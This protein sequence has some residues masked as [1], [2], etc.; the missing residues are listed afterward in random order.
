MIAQKIRIADL[1]LLVRTLYGALQGAKAE[2]KR[3]RATIAR[4]R[5][6]ARLTE[7]GET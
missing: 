7:K 4:L 3:H 5:K 6:K 1:E 2:T